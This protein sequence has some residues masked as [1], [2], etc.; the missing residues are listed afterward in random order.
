MVGRHRNQWSGITGA[1]QGQTI[2]IDF[3]SVY[4]SL[5][6]GI[7]LSRASIGIQEKNDLSGSYAY[8]LKL[9][10]ASIG[11]GLQLSY[12]QFVNDFTKEGLIAIDGFERDPSLERIRFVSGSFNLGLGF[13]LGADKYY[14][15]LSVPRLVKTDIDA[16]GDNNLTQE[17]RHLYGM[18]GLKF[19][20]NQDW[21]LAPKVLLKLAE[22][23]PFDLDLQ[24]SFI[25]Q[26]QLHLG[27]NFR[28]GGTQQ[29]LLESS[30]VLIGF[31]F[32]KNIFASMSYDF[33]TTALRQY[34]DGSFE[35]L[36][37]YTVGKNTTP[38][39]IQNP[40]YY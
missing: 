2:L 31:N 13:F 33:N 24:S 32:T 29:S 12:R 19:V 11:L 37:K 7:N 4:K 30:S 9:P 23:A 25:Y 35:L 39:S 3:P 36:L 27:V 40:R 34:E 16:T 6:F 1:P 26:D 5:G 15:G 10:K 21:K 14:I 38:E 8:R 17:V 22:N 20:L 28:A 18:L